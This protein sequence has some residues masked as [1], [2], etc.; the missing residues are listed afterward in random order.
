MG[1]ENRVDF[2]ETNKELP[3]CSKY[4]HRC[5]PLAKI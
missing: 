1:A 3:N 5:S 4:Q 2:K